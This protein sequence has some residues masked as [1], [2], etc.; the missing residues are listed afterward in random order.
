MIL[1]KFIEEGYYER[2]LNKMRSLYKN[3]HDILLTS[4]KEMKTRFTIS[5]EHA[6]VHLLLHF[7]DGRSEKELIDKAAQ[8]GVKVYG[9]SQYYVDGKSNQEGESVILLGY[10]NMNDEKIRDAIQL[11]DEAWSI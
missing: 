6:G 10:A 9:L 8:K 2:H 5:G 11:L 7:S 1:Q 3:R 4:L